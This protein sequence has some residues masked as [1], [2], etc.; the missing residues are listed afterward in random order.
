MKNIL[1]LSDTHSY[2]DK[3]AEEHYKNADE[4]W[5]AGDIGNVSVTDYLKKFSKL[6]AVFGNIDDHIIR[7]EFPENQ[8]FEIENMKIW[9]IHIG[10]Y[11]TKYSKKIDQLLQE[12]KPDI[13]ICGHSHILK[14]IFDKK[15]NLLHLNP[16]AFGKH[17]FHKERTMLKFKLNKGKITDLHIISKPK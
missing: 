16:G 3:E 10:G 13:F 11:P 7:K 12:I 1:L 8:I 17:G 4:I 14:V 6:R 9:M 15:K 5:H 2:I